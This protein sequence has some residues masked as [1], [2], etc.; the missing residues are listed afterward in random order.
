MG[1]LKSFPH[2][3]GVHTL[4]FCST[5]EYFKSIKYEPDRPKG[6]CSNILIKFNFR[7]A[8]SFILEQIQRIS[9]ICDLHQKLNFIVKFG[10]VPVGQW[11][12]YFTVLKYTWVLQNDKVQTR[13]LCG[14]AIKYG[15]ENFLILPYTVEIMGNLKFAYT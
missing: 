3:Y 2:A 12:S 14:K 4:S 8:D 6:R 10:K 9:K 7:W 5:H 13:S 1:D 11:G 15:I